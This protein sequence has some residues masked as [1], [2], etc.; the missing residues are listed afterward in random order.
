MSDPMFRSFRQSVEV[1]P[2]DPA[3]IRRRG[4]RRGRRT[5]IAAVVGAV[6]LVVAV[7]APVAALT[8]GDDKTT[9]PVITPTRTPTPNGQWRL[10]IPDDFPLGDGVPMPGEASASMRRGETTPL[11]WCGSHL[12]SA[13]QLPASTDVA[14]ATNSDVVG[15]ADGTD[16]RT[17][18]VYPD[19]ETA[20]QIVAV[21]EQA[22]DGCPGS[23]SGESER[24]E[25]MADEEAW[26]L[27]SASTPRQVASL[28][29]LKRV[30][31]ALLLQQDG[32]RGQD[33]STAAQRLAD[34]RAGQ[35]HVVAAMCLFAADACATPP[36][37]TQT[38]L[39]DLPTVTETSV[40]HV[41]EIP[42]SFPIDVD[43][44]DPGGDGEV[45]PTSSEGDPVLF[46]PCDK[47]AFTVASQDQLFFQVVGPEYGDT[48]ELRTYPSAD[49]AVRQMQ[50]LRAAVADC[51]RGVSSDPTTASIWRTQTVDTGYD[52][53]AAT[54]TYEQ[55]LG[56][57]VWVFTR[58]GRSIL[59]LAEGG[60]FSSE[61]VQVR[62]PAM[63]DRTKQI[64]PSMC[65]FTDA[66]C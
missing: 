51:P 48:R 56:G 27:T 53:F 24:A 59:A 37:A 50:R 1:T 32:L 21:I 40:A 30:G 64:V 31:N 63:V 20:K 43:Y 35:R 61:T 18:A 54:Q 13:D 15:T 62:L 5:T 17:L 16:T 9:P 8:H 4:E 19:A 34:I 23:G 47:D 22:L 33:Q 41:D 25:R 49:D 52:S 46:F 28:L 57:G 36:A 2:P 29:S 45:H 26:L 60:E 65:L 55:G 38:S 66:G 12:W 44:T 58:V 42:A 6:A 14:S 7:V 10:A 11:T 39:P 3:E